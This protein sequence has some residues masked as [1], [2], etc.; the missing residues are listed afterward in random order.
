MGDYVFEWTILPLHL[1]SM[2]RIVADLR[3]KVSILGYFIS[4]V[5]GLTNVFEPI[6]ACMWTS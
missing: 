6:K 4:N 2:G 1:A 5:N 3:S